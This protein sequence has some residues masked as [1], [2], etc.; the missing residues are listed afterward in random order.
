M[1]R[2]PVREQRQPLHILTRHVGLSLS[3]LGHGSGRK[4]L[5]TSMSVPEKLRRHMAAALLPYAASASFALA[6]ELGIHAEAA[7]RALANRA[8]VA[9]RT[10]QSPTP[11]ERHRVR[12][13]HLRFVGEGGRQDDDAPSDTAT[14]RPVVHWHDGGSGP[15]LLLLNGWSASGLVWPESW[16]AGLEERYR[17]IRIDNRGTGWSRSA[18]Y[19]FTIADMADDARDVLRACR[20]DRAVVLGL[21]M[22]GMIAQELAI[23]HAGLVEKLVLAATRPPAPTYVPPGADTFRLI[24]GHPPQNMTMPEFLAA[25][26]AQTT[27]DGFATDNPAVMAEIADQINERITPRSGVF[28][29]ARA[30]VGWHG[31]QRL[32]RISTPTTVVHG[33]RDPLIPVENGKRLEKLISHATYTQLAGVGHLVA[34]E[35]GDALLEALSV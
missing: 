26:W 24:L 14:Q 27:G 7:L 31:V 11:R 32:S 9:A 12:D 2:P 13:H 17:V 8:G 34:H 5:V 3:A 22:G 19:P 16:L 21:S 23:R 20:I 6:T 29:Q 4:A 28:N 25:T 35:A 15:A 30:I 10:L 18:P 33:E 1:N